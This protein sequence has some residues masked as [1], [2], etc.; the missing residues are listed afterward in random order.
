M[1]DLANTGQQKGK[2]TEKG[3]PF[4]ARGNNSDIW[5]GMNAIIIF[6]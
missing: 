4:K 5:I 3:K 2:Y 6:N 1:A